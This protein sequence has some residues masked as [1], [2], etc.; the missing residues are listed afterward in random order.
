MIEQH[1]GQRPGRGL[2]RG[3]AR[4]PRHDRPLCS[5]CCRTCPPSRA[6]IYEDKEATCERAQRVF[7]GQPDHHRER[8]VLRVPDVVP[9]DPHRHEPVRADHRRRSGASR[10]TTGKMKC[11]RAGRLD[12]SVDYRDVL[13]RLSAITTTLSVGLFG[14]S[15]IMLV[16]AVVLVANTLRMGMFAR[17]KEI[18][19]MRLVGATNWR[20]RVPFLIE[21]GVGGARRAPGSPSSRCSSG[22]SSSS[23]S[24]PASCLAAARSQQRRAGRPAVDHRAPRSSSRPSPARSA[25]AASSTCS[26]RADERAHRAPFRRQDRRD[27]PQGAARLRAARHLRVRD[28]ADRHRGQVAAAGPSVARGLLRAHARRRALARGACT[29]PPTSRATSARTSRCGRASSSCIVASSTRISARRSEKSLS[30]VP[31]RVYFTHGVAKVEIAPRGASGSTRSASRSPSATPSG[32]PSASSAAAGD[33]VRFGMCSRSV[34]GHPY[35]G[36][37]TTYGGVLASIR[38]FAVWAKRAVIPDVTL[39]AGPI[40]APTT[41]SRSLPNSLGSCSPRVP[42]VGDRV[43]PE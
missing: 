23:T 30:L 1:H 32:R 25:C 28:P 38:T 31:L 10:T 21:G 5:R 24:W 3:H 13:D 14:L 34:C 7:A 16:S 43:S 2:R 8:A 39:N 26:L 4:A 20:I 27:Q 33:L 6:L 42:T 18:S 36:A 12:R 41:S 22:R 15:V 9:R 29:S 37:T 40:Q 35:T 19:I 17:R 11:S